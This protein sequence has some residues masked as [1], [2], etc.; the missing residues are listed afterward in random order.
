MLL[1]AVY[2]KTI[3]AEFIVP[4]GYYNVA[5][6]G[7]GLTNIRGSHA[8]NEINKTPVKAQAVLSV[9]AENSRDTVDKAYKR[10]I[11][12]EI[13]KY[14]AQSNKDET[15]AIAFSAAELTNAIKDI[16]IGKAPGKDFIHPEFLHDLDPKPV[17]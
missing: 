4:M 12:A 1:H 5:L 10:R 2:Y 14:K 17:S 11:K 15:I 6:P 8:V 3:C 13:K 7:H 16:K 9:L